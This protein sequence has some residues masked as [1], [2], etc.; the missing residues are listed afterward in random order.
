MRER[1]YP[2]ISAP[3]AADGREQA[4]G[5]DQH[6]GYHHGGYEDDE[7]NHGPLPRKSP[8]RLVM[9]TSRKSLCLGFFHHI[10]LLPIR[11]IYFRLLHHGDKL[12]RRASTCQLSCGEQMVLDRL[13]GYPHR[14]AN[15]AHSQ[16]S[17]QSPYHLVL[18]L[19]QLGQRRFFFVFR[20]DLMRFPAALAR[21]IRR[22]GPASCNRPSPP[23]A[24]W[25]QTRAPRSTPARSRSGSP[26]PLSESRRN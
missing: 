12:K 8:G 9:V 25:K 2:R 20:H 1:I 7:E 5:E 23:P 16:A 13:F 4:R 24:D 21:K 3:M 6:S 26:L 17:D 10:P 11:A 14:Q 15:L 18:A 19:G 22:L